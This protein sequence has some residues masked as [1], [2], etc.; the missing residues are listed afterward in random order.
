M[1]LSGMLSPGKKS[2]GVSK[3][4]IFCNNCGCCHKTVQPFRN[5]LWFFLSL[6]YIKWKFGKNSGYTNPLLFV[7]WGGEGG[8]ACMI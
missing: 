2:L 6:P 3:A 5:I 8:W 1:K 7:V 4:V